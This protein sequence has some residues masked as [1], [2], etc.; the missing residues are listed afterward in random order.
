MPLIVGND[1]KVFHDGNNKKRD[2]VPKH[3]MP[4]YRS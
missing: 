2:S 3:S 1:R 4:G